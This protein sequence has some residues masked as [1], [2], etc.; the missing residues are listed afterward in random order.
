LSLGVYAVSD[1]GRLLA[2]STDVT[3]FREYT[4]RVKNLETGEL[5]P[6]T[7]EKVGSVQ[8]ASR[9]PNAVLHHGRRGQAPVSSV[10]SSRRRSDNANDAL[11][12]EEADALYRAFAYRSRDKR[13]LFFGSA[14][15]TT[16]EIAF[17][18]ATR[19]QS[20]RL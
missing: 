17:C 19:R 6:D 4:L 7:I 3:G 15:S 5:L 1:D 8:W 9:Q 10:S 2:Y 11:V 18:P 20:S 16:T 13:Y 12:Y 14:S